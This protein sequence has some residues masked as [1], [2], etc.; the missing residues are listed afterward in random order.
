MAG[1]HELFPGMAMRVTRPFHLRRA[2]VEIADIGIG[3]AH[4]ADAQRHVAVR[5]EVIDLACD[6]A[7]NPLNAGRGLHQEAPV[8]DQFLQLVRHYYPRTKRHVV[9]G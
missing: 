7:C 9:R 2:Q 4:Q 5:N 6:F 3:F 1:Q 8:D